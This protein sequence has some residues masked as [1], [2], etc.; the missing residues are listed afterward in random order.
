[1]PLAEQRAP[2][3]KGLMGQFQRAFRVAQV[4]RLRRHAGV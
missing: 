3:R 1:M 2:D 4:V